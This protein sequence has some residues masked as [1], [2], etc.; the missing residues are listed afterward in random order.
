MNVCKPDAFCSSS[1]ALYFTVDP[2]VIMISFYGMFW[3]RSAS[4]S[5]EAVM[6]A[7]FVSTSQA[8]TRSTHHPI[9]PSDYTIRLHHP[10]TPSVQL[11]YRSA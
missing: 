7:G 6:M 9:T 10:I 5:K 11:I 8:M 4:G 2:S 1:R 3:M